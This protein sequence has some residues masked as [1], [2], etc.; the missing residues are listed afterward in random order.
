M[1]MFVF[2]FSGGVKVELFLYFVL[3]VFWLVMFNYGVK[4]CGKGFVLCV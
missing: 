3:D 2:F 1:V 4:F